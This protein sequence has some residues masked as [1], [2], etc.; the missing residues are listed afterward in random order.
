MALFNDDQVLEKT[1]FTGIVQTRLAV[2]DIVRKEGFATL[3]LVFPDELLTGLVQG[4]S[5]ALNGACLTVRSIKGNRVSF[6]AIDQ[7]LSLTNLGRLE[8]GAQVNIERA[9][10]FGDEV[11][12]HMLSGHIMRQVKV[13]ALERTPHNCK[14]WFDRPLEVSPYLLNKGYVA[15][16]GCSLTIADVDEAASRFA[17]GLIPETLEVTTFGAAEVGDLINLEVDPQTQA[18]VDT[19]SRLLSDSAHLKGLLDGLTSTPAKAP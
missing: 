8:A 17:V 12:G 11:G 1:M 2:A 19:V 7:T 13:V 9:A 18:V 14:L 4:A 15:L 3:T 16:N 6:D 10:K 5:V